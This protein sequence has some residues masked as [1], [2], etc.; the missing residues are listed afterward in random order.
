[1]AD[2][3]ALAIEQDKIR[4]RTWVED[5]LIRLGLSRDHRIDL[6]RGL[7]ILSVLLLHF[8]FAYNLIKSP[9]GWFLSEPYLVNFVWNGNYGVTVFFVISGYLI[10]ST[11]LRRFGSLG[12]VSARVF[13]AFRFARIFPCLL[14]MLAIISVLAWVGLDLFRGGKHVPLWLSEFSVLTFWHNQLMVHAGYDNYCLDILWSLSVEEVFYLGFPLLCLLLKKTRW[15][16]IA[17]IAAIVIGPIYRS[18]NSHNEIKFLYGYLACF[19]A[20]AMGCCVAV[21][22]RVVSV[23]RLTRNLMQLAALMWM[24]FIFLRAGID[25]TPVWGPSLMGLGAAVYLF[26][27]GAWREGSG[28][29]IRRS[30]LD[31]VSAPVGWFGQHS[32]EL[33]LFHIVLLAGLQELPVRRAI[34][35]GIKPWWFLMFLALSALIAWAIARFYSEPLNRGLRARLVSRTPITTEAG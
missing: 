8:H 29:A 32:Y 15:I 19:D 21:L 9:L 22:V 24:L 10:T 23:G 31:T 14:L 3:F 28:G 13:Y 6:L 4:Q 7:S 27:E 11:S 25:S 16:V 1:V 30:V 5:D 33:Y 12:E 18:M 2:A 35:A 20:I 34:P 17:W 26:A